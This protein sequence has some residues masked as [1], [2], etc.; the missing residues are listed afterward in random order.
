MQHFIQDGGEGKLGGFAASLAIGW[1][2]K[3]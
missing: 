1:I 2:R 3:A